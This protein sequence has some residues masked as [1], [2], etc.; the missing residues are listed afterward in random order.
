MQKVHVVLA[1]E[2]K[3]TEVYIEGLQPERCPRDL[4]ISGL[5]VREQ[6]LEPADV[7]VVSVNHSDIC[8]FEQGSD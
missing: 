6:H 1:H 2:G 5:L 8:P 7:T 3:I 4:A